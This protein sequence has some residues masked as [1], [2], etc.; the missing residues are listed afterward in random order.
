MTEI[1]GVAFPIPKE[2]MSR[3]FED[4]KTVFIKPASLFKDLKIGMKMVFYQSHEDTGYVGEA[5]IK[6]ILIMDDP[7]NFFDI[8]GDS[9]F[10]ERDEVEEYL[11]GLEKWKSVR[12][13]KGEGKKKKWIALELDNFK[14]YDNIKKPNRFVPVGGMYLRE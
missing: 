5:R 8:F 14:R 6:K 2:Y 12:A 4:G 10:L 9:I 1:I 13:R 11:S 7:L 3:F